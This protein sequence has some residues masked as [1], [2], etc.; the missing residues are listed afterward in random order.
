MLNTYT[1][2]EYDYVQSRE[3]KE[4]AVVRH[5]VVI[6]GAGPIG[7]IAALDCARQPEVCILTRC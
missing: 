6:I 5:P 7:L 1:F 3:Q 2:P 4:G